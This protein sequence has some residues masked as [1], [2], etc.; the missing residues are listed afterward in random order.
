MVNATPPTYEG[1]LGISKNRPQDKYVD[2]QMCYIRVCLLDL[3]TVKNPAAYFTTVI[4]FL[5]PF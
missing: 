3:E 4:F 1:L 5:F 2:T